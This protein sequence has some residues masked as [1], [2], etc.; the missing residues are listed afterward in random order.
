MK[1]LGMHSKLL[2]HSTQGYVDDIW[3]IVED[4]DKAKQ[5]IMQCRQALSWMGQDEHWQD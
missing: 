3:G 4:L 5:Y 1:N 2:Q